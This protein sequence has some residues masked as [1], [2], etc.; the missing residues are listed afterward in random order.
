MAEQ[1]LIQLSSDPCEE[2]GIGWWVH[3]CVCGSGLLNPASALQLLLDT[4]PSPRLLRLL[5]CVFSACLNKYTMVKK[6]PS[7]ER[8]AG[9]EGCGMFS[10]LKLENHHPSVSLYAAIMWPA[11]SDC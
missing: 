3:V 5:P 2:K 6:R 9:L 8:G 10:L 7:D 11:R 1:A 4:I